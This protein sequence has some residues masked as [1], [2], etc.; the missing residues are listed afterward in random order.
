MEKML[1]QFGQAQYAIMH[2]TNR[3]I[4]GIQSTMYVVFRTLCEKLQKPD[5]IR[6]QTDYNRAIISQYDNAQL[7]D[8]QTLLDW[9]NVVS[10]DIRDIAFGHPAFV[11]FEDIAEELSQSPEGG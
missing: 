11:H 5:S 8:V 4:A 9:M 7:W 1:A 2:Y 6:S 10:Y 3:A